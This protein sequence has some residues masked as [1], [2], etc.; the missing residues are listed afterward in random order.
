MKKL[1]LLF[2]ILCISY[3]Y[4]Q[5]TVTSIPYAAVPA[6]GTTITATDDIYS[7]VINLGFNFCFYGNFYNQCIIGTNGIVSFNILNANSYC[8]W[9]I[10]SAIPSAT[11][12]VNSIMFPWQDVDLSAGGSIKYYTT[13]ISPN[14]K[15]IVSF[16]SIPMFQCPA[17]FATEQV[18]LFESTNIIETHVLNKPLCSTWNGGNAIHGLQDSTG[19]S[20]DVVP[21]RNYPAQWTASNDGW[22]FTPIFTSC[23]SGINEFENNGS[24]NIS[25]NPFSNETYIESDKY[26]NDVT[27]T[28]K[29]MQGQKIKIIKNISGQKITLHRDNLPNGIYFIH[30]TKDNNVIATRKLIIID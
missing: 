28:I 30:L 6:I 18:I 15:F 5:Y 14:R 11:C 2:F 29:N 22:R 16:D 21:G 3:S 9:S 1:L 26:L 7:S 17:M 20:A 12:P 8:Q 19:V 10:N 23:P 4:G 24:I 13:G 25:P 27:L